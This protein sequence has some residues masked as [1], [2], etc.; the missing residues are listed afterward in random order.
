MGKGSFGEVVKVK[1]RTD[2][3]I[4]AI[5]RVKKVFSSMYQAK[6]VLREITLLR[7]LSHNEENIFTIKL[8]DAVVPCTTDDELHEV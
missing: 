7:K 4:Y 6:S 8:F 5:K 3:K 2:G 1:S